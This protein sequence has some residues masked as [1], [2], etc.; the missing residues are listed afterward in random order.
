MRTQQ[1]EEGQAGTCFFMSEG[2]VEE[3]PI[4][5]DSVTRNSRTTTTGSEPFFSTF[6][7]SPTSP[8]QGYFTDR[9]EP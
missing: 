9:Y 8:R 7:K 5:R 4:W 2:R 3:I 1:S 6:Y